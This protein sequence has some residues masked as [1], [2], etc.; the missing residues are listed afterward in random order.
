MIANR[1]DMELA[2]FRF[3]LGIPGLPDALIPRVRLFMLFLCYSP[4]SPIGPTASRG[5]YS[6]AFAKQKHEC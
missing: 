6:V 1:R 4:V 3:T 2:V 5:L